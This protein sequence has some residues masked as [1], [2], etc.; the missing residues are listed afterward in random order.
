MANYVDMLEVG[1]Q[2]IA[3]LEQMSPGDMRVF[4][5]FFLFDDIYDA[6]SDGARH[7]ISTE[8]VEILHSRVR[9]AKRKI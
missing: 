9:E 7:G 8:C 4:L 6:E 3:Y 1:V 2:S 5:K